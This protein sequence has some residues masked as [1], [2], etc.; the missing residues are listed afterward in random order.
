MFQILA[1]E[2]DFIVVSKDAGIN[3]H[4]EDG[5]TGL[6]VEVEKA[7]GKKLFGV[8]RLDKMTSG[9]ILFATSQTAAAELSEMFRER[10]VEKYYLA[11]SDQ[12]PRKKQGLIKGDMAKSR[13]GTYKLMKTNDNPAATQFFSY[14]LRPGLRLYVIKPTTGKTHQI[15]VALKS[16]GAPSIGDSSYGG[17]KSDRGYLHAYQ[18]DFI[19]QE[20]IYHYQVAPREGVEYL[21]TE[22]VERLSE[23]EHAG[24]PQALN[25]PK[26]KLPSRQ[27][28]V[29]PSE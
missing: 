29:P 11:I 6:L 9:L 23:L 13:R 4:T 18:L 7:I 2:D 12:K 27:K 25:W 1:Q 16:V 5:V 3:F 26:V 15:R 8:H 20:K 22:C 10:Q 24:G 21:S 17:T 19:Y 28:P 14:S